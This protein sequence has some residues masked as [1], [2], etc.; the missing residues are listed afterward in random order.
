V[1]RHPGVSV[2]AHQ[3]PPPPGPPPPPPPP[4]PAGF[5]TPA[6]I[7]SSA[8]SRGLEPKRIVS[9]GRCRLTL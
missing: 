2:P 6:S 3:P 4:L 9:V 1:Y 5:Q 8:A 7:V